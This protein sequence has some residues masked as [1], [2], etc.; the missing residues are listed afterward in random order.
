MLKPGRV[1]RKKH[2]LCRGMNEVRGEHGREKVKAEDTWLCVPH[3]PASYHLLFTHDHSDS[4]KSPSSQKMSRNFRR[5]G[6]KKGEE[7]TQ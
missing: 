3:P 4:H 7:L 5:A 6:C 2:S 1:R